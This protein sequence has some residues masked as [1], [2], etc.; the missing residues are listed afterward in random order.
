MG[1]SAISPRTP[2]DVQ[3]RAGHESLAHGC[4]YMAGCKISFETAMRGDALPL[5]QKRSLAA[6]ATGRHRD[7]YINEAGPSSRRK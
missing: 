3:R 5:K 1:I 7:E 4:L 6:Y 2:M